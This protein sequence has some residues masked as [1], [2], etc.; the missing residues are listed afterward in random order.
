MQTTDAAATGEQGDT[1]RR[2]S[3][4]FVCSTDSPSREHL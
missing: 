3:K 2:V 4:G 1:D